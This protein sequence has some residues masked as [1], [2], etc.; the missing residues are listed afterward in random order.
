[1]RYHVGEHSDPTLVFGESGR[2]IRKFTPRRSDGPT[3][4][5]QYA[6]LT[7]DD[8]RVLQAG[9]GDVGVQERRGA[10]VEE[11][12][13][14]ARLIQVVAGD[15]VVQAGDDVDA[16]LRLI[17]IEADHEL[18]ALIA[19][20]QTA[21]GP[22]DVE[23]G[24]DVI[25]HNTSLRRVSVTTMIESDKVSLHGQD[26]ILAISGNTG[27]RVKRMRSYQLVPYFTVSAFQ[28]FP[29]SVQERFFANNIRRS[30]AGLYHLYRATVFGKAATQRVCSASSEE[31]TMSSSV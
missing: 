18:P 28:S 15:E 27:N 25:N 10:T 31:G 4:G 5:D 7:A 2:K 14:L 21:V 23:I 8:L 12:R 22:R 30:P 19:L 1:M 17:H 29:R 3:R 6:G 9:T 26:G 24:V 16:V 20:E 11:I 13:G